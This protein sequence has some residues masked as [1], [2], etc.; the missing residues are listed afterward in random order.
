[1]HEPVLVVGID[2][3][4]HWL[5]NSTHHRLDGPAYISPGGATSWLVHGRTLTP[6]QVTA[7]Q[8]LPVDARGLAAELW[9]NQ[10]PF[11]QAIAAASRVR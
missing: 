2:G 7:W 1:M 5:V 8:Q 4:Q 9:R 11:D 10:I 6:D 3:T